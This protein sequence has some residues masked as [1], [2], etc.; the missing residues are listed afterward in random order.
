MTPHGPT[1][2]LSWGEVYEW[3]SQLPPQPPED[4][5]EA[6][7]NAFA[8]AA[9]ESAKE[10]GARLTLDLLAQLAHRP[11]TVPMERQNYLWAKNDLQTKAGVAKFALAEYLNHLN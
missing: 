5:D 9:L 3:E 7:K 8:W 4:A 1:L 10:Q 2:H 6:T 11:R